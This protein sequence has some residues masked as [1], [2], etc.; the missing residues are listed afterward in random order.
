M[1]RV[2]HKAFF[3]VFD[4]CQNFE[5]FNQNPQVTEGAPA[6]ICWPRKLF[7]QRVELLGEID[8]RAGEGDALVAVREDTAKRLND[9]VAAMSLDNF[10]VRPKRRAVEKFARPEAWHTLDLESRA[11]LIDEVA[12]LPTSL[13][14][15]DQDAKQFDLL[16]LRTQ[17]ALLQLWTVSSP[18]SKRRSWKSPASS[19]LF[20]TFRWSLRSL[21]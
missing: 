11:Q 8:K 14:D 15:D 5:F 19:S 18:A 20:A 1:G 2:A 21:R 12:G 4:F 10:I 13:V 17:L 3:S 6:E 7:R 16:L 9:E